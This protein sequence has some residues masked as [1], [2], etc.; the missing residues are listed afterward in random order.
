MRGQPDF[1]FRFEPQQWLST[2]ERSA[3][4]GARGPTRVL[5]AES[6]RMVA[7]ALMLAIEIEPSLDPIGYA[8]GGWEALELMES[9]RPDVIVVGPQLAG[10]ED[11][12][13][14][15][16]LTELYPRVRLVVLTETGGRDQAAQD[17]VTAVDYLPL[18]RSTDELIDAI[19]AAFARPNRLSLVGANAPAEAQDG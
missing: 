1:D 5:F 2:P 4:S 16:L 12:P 8:L 17:P 7:E 14:L 3:A 11:F 13:V 9:L 10:E 15:R 19:G 18:D 6:N